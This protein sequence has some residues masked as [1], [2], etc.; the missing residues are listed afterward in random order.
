[1]DGIFLH[2]YKHPLYTKPSFKED[3]ADD[4][5][6]DMKDFK[7]LLYDSEYNIQPKPDEL[8]AIIIN[9]LKEKYG[10]DDQEIKN[11]YGNIIEVNYLECN[12]AARD[13]NGPKGQS[14]IKVGIGKGMI[15]FQKV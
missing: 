13:Q 15:W 8:K 7:D 4:I 5:F 12:I 10:N 14:T 11:I 3:A 9:E 1:M 2:F 6:L